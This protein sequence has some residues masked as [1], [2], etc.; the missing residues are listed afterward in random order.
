[1]P[2]KRQTGIVRSLQLELFEIEI[3]LSEF[4]LKRK[5]IRARLAQLGAGKKTCTKCD[6]EMEIEQFYVDKQKSDKRSSWCMECVRKAVATRYH[7]VARKRNALSRG[8]VA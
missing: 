6:E 7:S 4:E 1:M 2:E 8:A 3:A 5:E